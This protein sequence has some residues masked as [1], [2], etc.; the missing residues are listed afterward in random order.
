ID[1]LLSGE[2]SGEDSAPGEEEGSEES[3]VEDLDQ[4]DI[5]TFFSGSESA[6][7]SGGEESGKADFSGKIDSGTEEE[8]LDDLFDSLEED[9]KDRSF[10]GDDF[11]FAEK[12]DGDAE[13]GEILEPD[14]KEE[15][16]VPGEEAAAGSQGEKKQPAE[17]KEGKRINFAGF[18]PYIKD[19]RVI[20]AGVGG[21]LAVFIAACVYVLLGS[22]EKAGERQI[23]QFES[24]NVTAKKNKKPGEERPEN[25]IPVAR[26][27]NYEMAEDGGNIEITLQA[28]DQDDD[29]LTFTITEKPC[30]GRLS[31]NPPV[32]TYL[33]SLDFS[34]EDS[35]RFK[36]GDGR[37]F[38]KE[39][40]IRIS[41]PDLAELAD[42]KKKGGTE[43]AKEDEQKEKASRIKKLVADQPPIRAT[44][45]TMTVKSTDSLFLDFASLWKKTNKSAY[46]GTVYCKLDFSGLRGEIQQLDQALYRY[47]ADPFFSGI[48]VVGYRFK[49]NGISSPTGE[50]TIRVVPGDPPPEVNIK[51]MERREYAVGE[52]VVIDASP[53]RDDKKQSLKF[54]WSQ[55]SGVPVRIREENREGSRISFIMP[56]AYSSQKNP[57]PLLKVTVTDA[58]GQEDTELIKTRSVSLRDSALWRGDGGRITGN[59]PE[60]ARMLPWPYED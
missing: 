39:A 27:A 16:E 15:E 50:I 36:A 46:N 48:E 40:V 6:A 2:E 42:R 13:E 8:D 30:Y 18:I 49:K 28:V 56:S 52:T 60:E 55:V 7:D 10:L 1:A 14:D 4:K 59:P 41:G 51:K 44:S 33:P 9:E 3:T 53:S 23:A 58:G 21:S 19:K 35:F 11:A 37:D 45:T 38:S 47:K 31:G 25:F 54:N 12:V 43:K 26:N 22:G 32:L 17:E 24:V 34:G 29:N 20:A 57:G 5:D